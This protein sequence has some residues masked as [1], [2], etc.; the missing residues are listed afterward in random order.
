[1][2]KIN[3][4]N[5]KTFIDFLNENENLYKKR[6]KIINKILKNDFEY[7]LNYFKFK[8]PILGQLY[9][10]KY[11]CNTNLNKFSHILNSVEKIKG[12]YY[13]NIIILDNYHGKVI[14]NITHLTLECVYCDVKYQKII[15]LDIKYDY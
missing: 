4:E 7:K 3:I 12:N 2:F 5:E 13:G 9:N 8:E 1:M 10:K 6:E 15:R 14:S 11:N